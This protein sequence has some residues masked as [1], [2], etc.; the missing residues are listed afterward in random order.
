MN[1]TRIGNI[2]ISADGDDLV[3]LHD[4]WAAPVRIP[5]KRLHGWLLSRMREAI[6]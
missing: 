1:A 2:T 3:C 4:T 5:I 6:R